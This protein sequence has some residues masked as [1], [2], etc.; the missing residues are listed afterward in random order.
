MKRT[1]L[2]NLYKKLN[3]KKEKLNSEKDPNQKNII[4]EINIL[5]KQIKIMKNTKMVYIDATMS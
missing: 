1:Q 3:S 4:E 2:Q 5:E